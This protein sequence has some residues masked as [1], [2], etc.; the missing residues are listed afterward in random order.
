MTLWT[1]RRHLCPE[2]HAAK[3]RKLRETDL[4]AIVACNFKF[5]SKRD[6]Q[7]SFEVRLRDWAGEPRFKKDGTHDDRKTSIFTR[8]LKPRPCDEVE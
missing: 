3:L 5:R 4:R 7:Q 6:A 8:L 2:P 1:A